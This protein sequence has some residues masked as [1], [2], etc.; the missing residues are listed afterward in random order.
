MKHQ[1]Q[2]DVSEAAEC[3][4]SA[5]R[6]TEQTE[7]MEQTKQMEQTELELNRVSTY[8][9]WSEQLELVRTHQDRTELVWGYFCCI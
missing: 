1:R 8:Q 2:R 3:I 6:W 4:G 7:Q 5:W 9:R